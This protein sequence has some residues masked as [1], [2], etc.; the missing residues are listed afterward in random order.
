VQRLDDLLLK[1]EAVLWSSKVDDLPPLLILGVKLVRF[2]YAIIRDVLTTTLTLRAMGLVY[3][4][5]LSVVPMLALVFAGLKGFGFHRSNVEPALRNVL[6]PL[7][8]KGIELTDQLMSI[9]DNVQGGLLAGVGLLLLI[10]TTVSM[11]HKIEE[12]L[13][14][15]WR[16]DSTRSFVVRFGEYLSV[17]LVG[18]VL[19]FTAVAMIAAVSSNALVDKILEVSFLGATAVLIGKLMPYLL[20]SAV[21]GL[22]YWFMPNTQVKF[23]YALIGGLTGGMLW[24]FSG[25]VFAAFIVDSTRNASIYASFAIV[26]V[27]LIWLY[28]SWLILLI[29]AQTAFYAQKPEYLRMGYRPLLIGNMVREQAAMS[30]MLMI[31]E[32]FRDADKAYTTND[33][34]A[35]LKIPGIVLSPVKQRLITAGLLEIGSHDQLLPAR[36]PGQIRLIEVIDALRVPYDADIF[37]SGRWPDKVESLFSDITG[38]VQE[39]LE[40]RSLYDLLD[41]QPAGKI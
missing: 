10:Y 26:V 28:I 18:P 3:I 8:D 33:I 17:V 20:V 15:I 2:I 32:A 19:M 9:V 7:G 36:D 38:K 13:N 6:A 22:L 1:F 21:F 40:N 4:T 29:G 11:I 39:S 31:A 12:S 14:H 41:E 23:R 25:V 37:R 5:I 34:A 30:L 24:A 27:A 35:R 16:I